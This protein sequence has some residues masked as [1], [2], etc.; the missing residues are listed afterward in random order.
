MTR[1]VESYISWSLSPKLTAEI[2][3]YL[4]S[5]QPSHA[6]I[7]Y[8]GKVRIAMGDAIIAI[9]GAAGLSAEISEYDMRPLAVKLSE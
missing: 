9:L 3:E 4:L 1:L 8:S 7:Q 6:T 5:S 2:N